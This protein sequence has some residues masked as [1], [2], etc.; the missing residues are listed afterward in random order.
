MGIRT[1][2]TDHSLFGFDDAASIL[3]NKLLVGTLKNV[4]AVICVSHTGRE[5]TVLRG[6]LFEPDLQDASKH[7]VRKNV[8]VIPNAL[9]ADNFK[10]FPLKHTEII[11]IV[12]LSRLAYR[13]GIDLLVAT[14]PRICAAFPNVRFVVGGD[15]PK[16]IDLLQMR[17]KHLLQ[18]RIELLGPVRHSDVRSVLQQGA[19]F[20]NT[21]LTESFGIAILEA[22]CAGL[23]VVSTR[24]GGVPEI[25]PRDM[26]SFAEPEEDG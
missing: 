1:V 24:V 14:A 20:M 16:L 22:A 25:L 19:I 4:D 13:K 5:N 21:S 3:T 17:E 26:I 8:Y 11:T 2:F 12:V 6:E 18:E 9:I 10:P 15:G 7:V 23:Y